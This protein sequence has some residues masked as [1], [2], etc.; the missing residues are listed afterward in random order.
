[1]TCALHWAP[2]RD[3]P[4]APR[5]C[6]EP[7]VDCHGH[8]LRAGACPTLGADTPPD[9]GALTSA[10]TQCLGF[11]LDAVDDWW[12]ISVSITSVIAA[13]EWGISPQTVESPFWLV[14]QGRVR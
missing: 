12:R 8:S 10:R 5:R 3:A 11:C 2:P 13:I 7:D 4:G 14:T 1:M 9:P 6:H